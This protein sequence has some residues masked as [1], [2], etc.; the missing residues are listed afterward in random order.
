[1]NELRNVLSHE[2]WGALQRGSARRAAWALCVN[3]G[4]VVFAFALAAHAVMVHQ[5][6]AMCSFNSWWDF[7]A[8][9]CLQTG[10]Q[11]G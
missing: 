9:K 8:D 6:Q 2:Q 11:A 1:M 5:L 4:L 3:W 7:T 10:H